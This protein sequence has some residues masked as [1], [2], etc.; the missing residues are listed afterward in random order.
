MGQ[1][2]HTKEQ[3]G[4]MQR[5]LSFRYSVIVSFEIGDVRAERA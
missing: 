3:K 4:V 2:V 1:K 5:P